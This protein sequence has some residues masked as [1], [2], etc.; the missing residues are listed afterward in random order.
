MSSHSVNGC[1][2]SIIKGPH[3]VVSA[4]TTGTC[5]GDQLV[6]YQATDASYNV[7]TLVAKSHGSALPLPCGYWQADFVNGPTK[8][9]ID[10]GGPPAAAAHAHKLLAW[11]RGDHS[12]TVASTTTTSSTTSTTVAT[13]T[14]TSTTSTT[15]ATSTTSTTATTKPPHLGRH[16]HQSQPIPNPVATTTTVA[17]TM[18][19]PATTL[20]GH[21]AF[22][23][24]SAG[25][26]ALVSG[27]L[28]STGAVMCW[29]ARCWKSHR[30]TSR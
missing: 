3:G 4:A 24:A 13:S 29:A 21:L 10:H 1:H 20:P 19:A 12:C 2:A 11:R 25:S 14:T 28:L 27:V 22:T 5:K 16:K 23:G 8:P 17:T 18:V 6:L 15:D 9:V 26:E 30:S 7:Q